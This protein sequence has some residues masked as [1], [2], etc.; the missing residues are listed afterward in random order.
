MKRLELGIGLFLV[1]LV[2][3]MALASYVWTPF[4]PTAVLSGPPRLGPGWPHILGTDAMGIDIFSRI[5]VG[6]RS[7]I[8]VGV[9]AVGLAAVIGVPLGVITAQLPPALSMIVLRATDI[10]YAFPALL[11]ALLFASAL[12]GSTETAM[13]AIGLASIPLFLRVTRAGA[14][15]V[16]SSD[17]VLA[18]RACGTTKWGI[19]VRHILPNVAGLVGV[20][21][22]VTFAL[23]ILA[24]AALSYLGLGTPSTVPSWGR[25]LY[26]A[27]AQLFAD[28][29]QAVW[30]G[31]AIGAAVLGFNLVG[32]G[33]RDQLDPRLRDLA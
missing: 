8:S 7:A 1:G 31:L 21:A 5:L 28:P 27:Q 6:A 3:A 24:E 2:V 16:L 12:G 20:Q 15:A 30:P 29:W 19:T 33:L 23:A 26:D 11:L 10:A 14:L 25:M 13:L 22:S 17:Y 9:I 4:N 32:D 18:A